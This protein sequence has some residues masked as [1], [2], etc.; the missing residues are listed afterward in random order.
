MSA[1]PPIATGIL[2]RRDWSLS[3]NRRHRSTTACASWSPTINQVELREVL[4]GKAE[5]DPRAWE[6]LRSHLAGRGGWGAWRPAILSKRQRSPQG[7]DHIVEI[8][9]ELALFY[10]REVAMCPVAVMLLN[11]TAAEDGLQLI[12]GGAHGRP[13]LNVTEH[14]L[15]AVTREVRKVTPRT[16]Q[17]GRYELQQQPAI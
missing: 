12:G 8:H 13:P 10:G 5:N 11:E 1:M 17:P 9:D 14:L 4:D 16:T 6:L 15:K 3:A 2:Q 7:F